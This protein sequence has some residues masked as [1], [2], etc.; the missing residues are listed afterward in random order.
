[1]RAA[2]LLHMLM[3]LQNRGRQ[4]CATL[5]R[6]LEVSRR[7]ILRDVDAL[8]E[9]GLPVIMHRGAQGGV[10]LGFDYRTR[11]T[12]LDTAE[13]DAMALILTHVPP[14]L[15]HLGLAEAGR[16]A[17]AKVREAF[18]DRTR[19]RMAQMARLFPQASPAPKP[20][21]RR[22]A[23]ATAVRQGRIVRLQARTPT[24]ITVHPIALHLSPDGWA[25]EDARTGQHWPEASWG[26]VNISARLFAAQATLHAL[27][28]RATNPA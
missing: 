6:T 9:A 18:P 2:R 28:E 16:R 27:G 23:L 14:D 20:D 8:T 25:L 22:T 21:S 24:P 12:G 15:H 1:M 4:S 11:L 10:E 26:D 7:T 3:I 5:A 19:A 13:A 17:Q